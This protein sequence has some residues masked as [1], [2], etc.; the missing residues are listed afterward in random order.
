MIRQRPL[1][2]VEG[3][4]KPP[5]KPPPGRK[6]KQANDL[7]KILPAPSRRVIADRLGIK[8][9]RPVKIWEVD[10]LLRYVR[11]NSER[12]RWLPHH[13]QHGVNAADDDRFIVMHVDRTGTFQNEAEEDSCRRGTLSTLMTAVS[14]LKHQRAM[15]LAQAANT[16]G[17]KY[18]KLLRRAG[19]DLE[20]IGR[21]LA[22][23]IEEIEEEANGA[24]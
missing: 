1:Q 9:K 3:G 18:P 10:G 21:K 24:A 12:L 13:A 22:D 5:R 15:V 4:K 20:F 14:S 19:F 16:A 2:V 11:S 7:F 6:D 23:L 17:R 8:W